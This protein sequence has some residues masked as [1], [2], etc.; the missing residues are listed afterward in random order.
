MPLFTWILVFLDKYLIPLFF[1]IGL[2]YFIY[3][4]IEYFIIGIEGDEERLHNGREL[5]LRSIGW[6]VVSLILYGVFAVISWVSN[7][8]FEPS[9][10]VPAPSGG[11]EVERREELLEVPNVPSR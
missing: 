7:F 10:G 3:G 2:L 6:F 5:F 11:A 4:V 8:S 1:A 9:G